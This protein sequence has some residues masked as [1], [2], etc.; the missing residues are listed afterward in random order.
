MYVCLSS[1]ALKNLS[2]LR[3]SV[4]FSAL[5]LVINTKVMMFYIKPVH[6]AFRHLLSFKT[7]TIIFGQLFY[8]LSAK[9]ITDSLYQ[10]AEE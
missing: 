10:S 3:T 2:V 8:W 6:S 5:T 4:T 1:L 7:K 9:T